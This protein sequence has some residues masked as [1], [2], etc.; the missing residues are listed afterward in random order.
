MF[1]SIKSQTEKE[2]LLS[3]ILPKLKKTK[4][5]YSK[6]ESI[7]DII[8]LNENYEEYTCYLLQT[9]LEKAS[10]LTPTQI[11]N[12]LTKKTWGLSYIMQNLEEIINAQKI[13][14]EPLIEIIVNQVKDNQ[15][16][17]NNCINRFLYSKHSR[18]REEAIFYLAKNNLLPDK[19]LVVAALYNNPADILNQ[20]DESK[21]IDKNRD[22]LL[23]DLPY[24]IS[25]IKDSDY[26]VLIKKYYSLF[27]AAESKRKLHF[28]KKVGYISKEIE[29]KYQEILR[30][31][32]DPMVFTNLDFILSAIINANEG[33]FIID[34]I[35]GKDVEFGGMGTTRK[36]LKV[37]DDSILK[38]ARHLY[39][40][41]NLTE[42][43]LLCPN[44]LKKIT[45]SNSTTIYIEEEPYLSKTHNGK[46]MTEQDI[47]NFLM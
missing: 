25:A 30:L 29:E 43:F 9:N 41:E 35:K 32:E 28:I 31:A 44:K 21:V 36:V 40:D 34:R 38:F 3:I 11:E 47:E 12:L 4:D 20:T 10:S 27:F 1:N 18:L 39:S 19:E 33:D 2:E 6:I 17:L 16:L 46:K 5:W 24:L 15:D 14:P 8:Y 26:Q 42:H 7:F 45:V 22:L 23:S 37:G 13:Y